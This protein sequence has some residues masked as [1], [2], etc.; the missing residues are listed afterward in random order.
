MTT[1][2]VSTPANE[3]ELVELVRAG[4]PLQAVGSGTK[5]HHG[6]APS[7]DDATTVVLRKLN[8]ITAYEPGDLVVT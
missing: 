4:M 3:Q 7:H 8:K 6:P 1:D 2:V 5:R